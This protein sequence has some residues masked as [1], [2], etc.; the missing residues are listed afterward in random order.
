MLHVYFDD[1]DKDFG[2]E[3]TVLSASGI[4][5]KQLDSHLRATLLILIEAFGNND[6]NTGEGGEQ[7]APTPLS[8]KN[9]AP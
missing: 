7:A 5:M 9:N 3:N 1:P 2:D 6:M 8:L 4:S